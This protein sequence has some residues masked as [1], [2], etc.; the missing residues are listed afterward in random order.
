MEAFYEKQPKRWRLHDRET[1]GVAAA[2]AAHD[3]N[4]NNNEYE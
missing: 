2:E 1:E 4:N 3:D